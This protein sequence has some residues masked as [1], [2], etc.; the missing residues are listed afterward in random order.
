M[1]SYAFIFLK[2]ILAI[3]VV[4]KLLF[5]MK[6]FFRLH[7]LLLIIAFLVLG[8]CCCHQANALTTAK[9]Q[10][11]NK[12]YRIHD[13]IYHPNIRTVRLNRLDQELSFPVIAYRQG[14]KL[15][16]T[17]DDLDGDVK[18]YHYTVVHCDAKWNLSDLW[19]S[20]YI[21]GFTDETIEN[22]RF[23]FNTLQP[24]THYELI[25]P[26]ER[27]DFT[28]PGNYLLIVYPANDPNS[29]AFTRRFSV[30]DA[31]VNIEGFV[32]M[33]PASPERRKK[34]E[35]GFTVSSPQLRIVDP[36]RNLKVEV[37]QNNRWDNALHL[38][39]YQILG[40]VF[41]Y[42]YPDESNTFYAVNE[43]RAFDLR[44]VRYHT[45]G[46][47]EILRDSD[48][49]HIYLWP[50]Q[51]RTFSSYI[52]EN[53]LNGRFHIMAEDAFDPAVGSEYVYVHFTLAMETPIPGAGVYI[54]GMLSDWQFRDDNRMEYNM[55]R[56]AYEASMFLKQ[57]FYNYHYSLLPPGETSGDTGFFEGNHADTG[58]EYTIYVYYREP[59]KRY[60]SLIGIKTLN[61]RD[62]L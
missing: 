3:F 39:P 27:F 11:G 9:L 58:N 26:N 40:D 6:F 56:S 31:K 53:D 8:V 35:V 42:R 61:S 50:D 62:F 55:S 28:L 24:Y 46:V 30:L 25:L 38:Q 45:K 22:Y 51:R 47:R 34:H 7:K 1:I 16:L 59:G 44:S 23:S 43:F 2:H 15:Q 20:D 36:Y 13:D 4:T 19:P 10:R 48:N 37:R 32:R 54:T 21:S 57:G 5:F 18:L 52:H 49:Y 33:P 41:D 12:V 29:V 14:E 17:F 60:D